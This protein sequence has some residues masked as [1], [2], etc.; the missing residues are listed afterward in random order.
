MAS[1]RPR[2]QYHRL[3]SRMWW[4]SAR[5]MHVKDVAASHCDTARVVEIGM[6]EW[7]AKIGWRSRTQEDSY[8]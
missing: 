3:V 7:H 4:S 8:G 5:G 6:S 1:T 2:S